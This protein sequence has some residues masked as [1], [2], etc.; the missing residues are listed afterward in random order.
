MYYFMLVMV[1][2]LFGF[3][4]VVWV[5]Y[6]NDVVWLVELIVGWLDDVCDYVFVLVCGDLLFVVEDC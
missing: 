5:L 6:V 4:E 2:D 1:G 3:E